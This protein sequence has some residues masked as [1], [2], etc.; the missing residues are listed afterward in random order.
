M[1]ISY[2][3]GE[4]RCQWGLILLPYGIN[5]KAFGD[6]RFLFAQAAYSAPE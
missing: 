2:G 3:D 5:T 6:A 4:M 1:R